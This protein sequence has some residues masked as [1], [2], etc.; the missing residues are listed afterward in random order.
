MHK[1]ITTKRPSA[2]MI[3]ALVVLIFSVTGA[4]LASASAHGIPWTMF[5]FTKHLTVA[6]ATG[7]D[8]VYESDNQG[9]P[10]ADEHVTC[11]R[12]LSRPHGRNVISCTVLECVSGL[13]TYTNSGTLPTQNAPVSTIEWTD[14]VRPHF[15]DIQFYSL[16]SS[17]SE[18]RDE[19]N[20]KCGTLPNDGTITG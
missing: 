7:W 2:S 11:R 1:T 5:G 8:Q 19:S 17:P 15:N 16:D 12:N 13:S 20:N 6:A 10:L 4:G 3:A 9:Y 18:Y 14:W